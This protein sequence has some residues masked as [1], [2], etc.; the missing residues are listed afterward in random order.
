MN[1]P[2]PTL[3]STLSRDGRPVWKIDALACAEGD[4][5]TLTFEDAAQRWRQGIWLAVDGRLA[6]DDVESPQLVLWRDTAPRVVNL[7]VRRTDD[8]LLRLYNVWDSGRGRRM[9]SQSATSGMLRQD[10]ADGYRYRCTDIGP[11]PDFS[12]LTFSLTRA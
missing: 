12:A 9:E 2:Q 1:L 7:T 4:V 6:V 5:F 3:S 8:R 10:L 11:D